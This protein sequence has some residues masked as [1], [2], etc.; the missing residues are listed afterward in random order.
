MYSFIHSYL[1][2][3]TTARLQAFKKYKTAFTPKKVYQ[4]GIDSSS[5]L[6]VLERSEGFGLYSSLGDTAKPM[7]LP[8]FPSFTQA[9]IQ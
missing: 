9:E 7:N 3:A 1:G 6:V 2:G 5:K 4:K 8:L